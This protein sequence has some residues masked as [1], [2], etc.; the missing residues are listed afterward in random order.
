MSANTFSPPLNEI[1]PSLL[2]LFSSPMTESE[3]LA[4]QK[5]LMDYYTQMLHEEVEKIIK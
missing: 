5:L 4:L 3:T 2:K 1:H